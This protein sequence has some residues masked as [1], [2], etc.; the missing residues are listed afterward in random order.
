MPELINRLEL[1]ASG[2]NL[3]SS[4]GLH[5]RVHGNSRYCGTVT[6]AASKTGWK[7]ELTLD[8]VSAT[9]S[10]EVKDGVHFLVFKM[11]NA[12]DIRAR[13][14]TDSARVFSGFQLEGDGTYRLQ[15]PRSWLTA[16]FRG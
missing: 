2:W 3:L 15:Q 14:L 10:Q 12:S 16:L 1:R 8:D 11:E 9:I 7:W 6:G 13:V 4:R 5:Y